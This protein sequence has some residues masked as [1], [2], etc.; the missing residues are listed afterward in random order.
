MLSAGAGM[1]RF[2]L[3]LWG[4]YW[5]AWL[6]AF[7]VPEIYW[8]INHSAYTLS[9]N[10]WALENLSVTHPF[11]LADWTPGHW[12]IALTVWLLFGWLSLHIPFGLLR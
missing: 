11:N 8:I 12:A 6:I 3:T 9:D 10:T 7:L 1:V 2:H 5:L 4:D